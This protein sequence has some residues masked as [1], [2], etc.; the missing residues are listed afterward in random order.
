MWSCRA[1]PSFRCYFK[2]EHWLG[3]ENWTHRLLLCS[4]SLY[5]LSLSLLWLCRISYS[6]QDSSFGAQ[7]IA[8]ENQRL[9]VQIVDSAIAIHW[10]VI[11]TLDSAIQLLNKVALIIE[12]TSISRRLNQLQGIKIVGISIV[13]ACSF[14]SALDQWSGFQWWVMIRVSRRKCE[15]SD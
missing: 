12:F 10:I 8:I 2:T 9:V 4:Q 7:N 3:P 5:L 1:V 13:T 15:C 14:S 11:Y 6:T